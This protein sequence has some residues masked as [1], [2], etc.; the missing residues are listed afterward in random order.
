MEFT[1][2]LTANAIISTLKDERK[3]VNFTLAIND[4]YKPKG[5]AEGKQATQYIRCSYWKNTTVA[6]RL[7]K[8]SVVEISGRLFTTVYVS[9]GGEARANLN[10]IC[11]TIKVHGTSN[12]KDGNDKPENTVVNALPKPSMNTGTTLQEEDDIP[13]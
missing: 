4:Y 10:A 3:V 7:L 1:G 8:G 9:G 6:Q 2:R 13:F 12:K 11:S 5:A